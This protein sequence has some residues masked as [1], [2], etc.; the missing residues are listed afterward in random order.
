MHFAAFF[1][2]FLLLIGITCFEKQPTVTLASQNVPSF[3][4]LGMVAMDLD[5]KEVYFDQ[6]MDKKLL[7]A[8]VSKLMTLYTAL[9]LYD[10]NEICVIEKEDLQTYGSSIYL[11]EG[12]VLKVEDLLYGLMLQSGNDAAKALERH[13]NQKGDSF[14][15][16]MNFYA[17]KIGM[18]NSN[19]QNAS[20]LDEET[21]NLTTA[22][23]L[24]L[25]TSEGMKIEA[26]KKIISCKKYSTT[27]ING[28]KRVFT[29]KHKLVL[30]YEFATSGKT[31]YTKKA[32]RTLVTCFERDDFRVVIVT[33]SAVNDWT[34]HVECFNYVY[35]HY[36]K[37]KALND[38]RK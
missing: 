31:G 32:G 14:I 23:D 9:Q 28:K 10:L 27:F 12:D 29:N 17:K 16:C 26:F 33:L 13:L 8:S 37:K 25:L 2:S 15:S 7:P 34:S 18:T 36:G 3:S 22:Y 5:T 38:E 19:F 30:N 21:T 4:A 35:D 1:L 11:E 6:G 24:A 20:G